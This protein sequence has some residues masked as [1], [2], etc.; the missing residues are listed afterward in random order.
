MAMHILRR[1]VA[2]VSISDRLD[3]PACPYGIQRF[4]GKVGKEGEKNGP[5][6]LST[7]LTET[8]RSVYDRYS[9]LDFDDKGVDLIL[10][11]RHPLIVE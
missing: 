5:S 4:R 1:V 2:S 9:V 6:T 7:Q 11:N 3:L 10:Q 8:R